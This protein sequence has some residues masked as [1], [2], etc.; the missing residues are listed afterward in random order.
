MH[1][2][3]RPTP[4]RRCGYSPRAMCMHAFD[5]MGRSGAGHDVRATAGLKNV[6]EARYD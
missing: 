6:S 4:N 3:Q 5:V 2:N 1:S